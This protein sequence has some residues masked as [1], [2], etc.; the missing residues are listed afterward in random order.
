MTKLRHCHKPEGSNGTNKSE[1]SFSTSDTFNK[2]PLYL[3]PSLALSCH[4]RCRFSLAERVRSE[5]PKMMPETKGHKGE[6][7]K[8]SGVAFVESDGK[9]EAEIEGRK[10][11]LNL[12]FE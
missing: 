3:E 8:T 9:K 2:I 4:R 7:N 11:L 6:R 5:S 1:V 10:E 12:L